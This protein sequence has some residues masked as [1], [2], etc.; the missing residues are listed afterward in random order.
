LLTHA[1]DA[2]KNYLH[3]L[4]HPQ[5]ALTVTQAAVMQATAVTATSKNK[6]D[7]NNLTAYNSRNAS[8]SRTANTVGTPTTAG[9]LAS[10]EAGNSMQGGQ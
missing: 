4:A 5:H 10:N 1:E 9:M 8:N 6:G 3:F 2:L 7:N